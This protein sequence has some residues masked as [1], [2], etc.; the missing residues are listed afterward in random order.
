VWNY[1]AAQLHE[2]GDG[3]CTSN[4]CSCGVALQ[5]SIAKKATLRCSICFAA[6]QCNR[7]KEGD[8]SNATVAFFFFFVLQEK[9]GD[10]SIAAIAFFFFMLWSYVAAQL[11]EK[12]NDNC[13]RLLLR[14]WILA[15]F[16]YSSLTCDD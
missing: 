10:G 7:A 11:H 6:L 13:R 3:S 4:V 15:N 8:G 2:K 9:K 14:I 16:Y 5:R 1:V 12:G